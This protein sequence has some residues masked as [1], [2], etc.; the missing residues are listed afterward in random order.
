MPSRCSSSP[1]GGPPVDEVQRSPAVTI[2][3][4]TAHR[5]AGGWLRGAVAVEGDGPPL[6]VAV[7]WRTSGRCTPEERV[8]QREPLDASGAFEMRLPP[9]PT[10]YVGE[11]LQVT[12][13][14]RVTGR[15]QVWELPFEVTAGR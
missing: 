13:I 4:G 2:T 1:A 12:W 14:V 10:S 11:H 15:G 6:D 9:T 7:L 8:V 5:R 3:L